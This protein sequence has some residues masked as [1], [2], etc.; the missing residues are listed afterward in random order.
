METLS[1]L[2]KKGKVEN[3]ILGVKVSRLVNIMH[4][5]L[6]DNVLIMS[7]VDLNERKEILD[8]ILLFCK[9]TGLLENFSK[10]TVHYEGLTESELVPF[11]SLLDFPFLAMHL[12]FKYLGFYLKNG[13][14][15]VA[16]WLWLIRKIEKKIGVW[17]YKWLSL[18]GRF[19][20]LKMVL[21]SQSIYWMAVELIPKFILN[22]IRKLCFN[23]LWNGNNTT[24]HIHLCSWEA[25]SRPKSSG[26]WGLRNLAHF[27]TSLLANTLWDTLF[28]KGLWHNIVMDKYLRH[29]DVIQ[30]FISTNFEASIAS[31]I[32]RNLLKSI[33][34]LLHW[35]R[36]LPGSGE[37]ILIG[38]DCILG[39]GENSLLSQPLHDHLSR[40]EVKMLVN[41]RNP[42]GVSELSDLWLCSGS[43]GLNGTLAE[44]WNNFTK[45]LTVAGVYLGEEND[46]LLW[47]GGDASD[48][49]T[50]KN[51]YLALVSTQNFQSAP[52]GF[53]KFGAGIFN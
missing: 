30:W 48:K 8:R 2:L 37:Q 27:N 13:P 39:M 10:T 38:R 40:K 26:G 43:L 11:R 24:S 36:W 35:Q 25:L 12:G 4:L 41:A 42:Q 1:L 19:I 44:E 52:N 9:A 6:V 20:M 33:H 3:K 45:G 22:Q 7:N 46:K 31:R 34:L 15:R 17:C 53:R 14:Q 5:F 49:I 28:D 18:G 50:V 32:W 47:V 23:F 21:E 29:S 51:I 16:D